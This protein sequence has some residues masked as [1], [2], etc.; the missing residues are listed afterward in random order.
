MKRSKI[1]EEEFSRFRA[2]IQKNHINFL[3]K[4]KSVLITDY[5][6]VITYKSGTIKTIPTLLAELPKSHLK[7]EWTWNFDQTGADLYNCRSQFKIVAL[8]NYGNGNRPT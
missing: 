7:E 3:I 4:H 2:E 6:E 1:K 8:I 5:S